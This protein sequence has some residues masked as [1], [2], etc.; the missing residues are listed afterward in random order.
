MAGRLLR[1]AWRRERLRLRLLLRRPLRPWQGMVVLDE[2]CLTPNH[3]KCV[4]FAKDSQTRQDRAMSF[5]SVP[6]GY[7]G[8]G[9]SV[10]T[11]PVTAP[12]A[13]PCPSVPAKSCHNLPRCA[14][15][16]RARSP[17][18][19]PR[20]QPRLCRARPLQVRPARGAISATAE[21]PLPSRLSASTLPAKLWRLVNS[22]R[23]RSVRW[24]SR[25]Q[26]LLVDR[27]LFQRELLSLSNACQA[28]PYSLQATQFRSFVLQLHRYSFHRVPGW[29]G[30]AALGNAGAWLRSGI[31]MTA[32]T[33]LPVSSAGVRPTGSSWRRGGK[34]TAASSSC[35]RSGVALFPT[36]Q[37][38]KTGNS[39]PPE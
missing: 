6:D 37:L 8:T 9:C 38:P 32:P 15:P 17:R 39:C 27:W 29:V 3:E 14:V 11:E 26:G 22:P 34:A 13:L 28:A 36:G 23:V 30:S 16:S 19:P 10:G 4:N 7:P 35:T 1:T 33:S 12:S 2:C 18:E 25:A 21:L 5:L 20:P 24:D 31:A